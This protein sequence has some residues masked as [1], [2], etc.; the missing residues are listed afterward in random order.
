MRVMILAPLL[1]ACTEAGTGAVD[2]RT[3]ERAPIDRFSAAAGRLW[4]RTAT[5]GLPEANVPIDY[6]A[7]FVIHGLGPDGRRVMHYDFDVKP[8]GPAPIYVL[9]RQGRPVR[10]QL[11]VVTVIPGDPGY[12]DLWQVVT[13]EVP[14][15][16]VANTV[17]SFA[18]IADAGY[19]QTVTRELVNCP[20]VPEGSVAR[21]RMPGGYTELHQGWYG[22]AI[23]QYFHF[24]EAALATTAAGEA[25]VSTIHVAYAINPGLPG[26][27]AASGFVTEAGGAQTH[28]VVATAPSD[29]GY[30][31]LWSVRAYDNAAF[32]TVRDLA[33]AEAAATVADDA[34]IVNSPIAAIDP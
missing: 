3:A 17:T 19:A 11:N 9:A 27:G 20:V 8:R 21:T 32:A 30:A 22:G 12:N 14:E 18:E 29:A 28:N 24:G 6:D 16:Y 10:D 7:R 33:T 26:G 2:P 31:P 13:V 23:I 4:V 1:A 5:N 15:D 25:P 34:V